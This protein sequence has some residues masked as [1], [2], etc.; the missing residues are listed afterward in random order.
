M[1]TCSDVKHSR[2]QLL[3]NQCKMKGDHS[4]RLQDTNRELW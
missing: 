2:T 3:Q 4:A 1:F